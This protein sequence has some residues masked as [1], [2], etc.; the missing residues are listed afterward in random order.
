[1]LA[2]TY[3]A[4]TLAGL[5]GLA[6]P[7]AAQP[8]ETQ[9]AFPSYLITR[10]P[11]PAVS[12]VTG[13]FNADGL[14][15]LVWISDPV[16]GGPSDFG[17]SITV[18]LSQGRGYFS[19]SAVIEHAASELAVADFDNDGDDDLISNSGGVT[20]FESLGDGSF[21]EYQWF[22]VPVPDSLNAADITGD[23][24]P[25]FFADTEI[26][27]FKGNGYTWNPFD[28]EPLR[29]ATP[30]FTSFLHDVNA[31]GVP[32]LVYDAGSTLGIQ[33]HQIDGSPGLRDNITIYSRPETSTAPFDRYIARPGMQPGEL[34]AIT[35]R[36]SLTPRAFVVTFDTS[37]VPFSVSSQESL[38]GPGTSS[39]FPF[40]ESQ[41][42]ITDFDADGFSDRINQFAGTVRH[43]FLANM[44]GVGQ[45][46][47]V[48]D[49]LAGGPADAELTNSLGARQLF[50]DVTGDGA[51]DIL[52][53]GRTVVSTRSATTPLPE[54]STPS[55]ATNIAEFIDPTT[56]RDLISGDFDAD[57]RP[58][59]AAINPDFIVAYA[60]DQT[61]GT[62][63]LRFT[64]R[65]AAQTTGR[66]VV[67]DLNGD[68]VSDLLTVAT[69]SSRLYALTSTAPR[70][71]ESTPID[72]DRPE[73]ASVTTP[74]VADLDNDGDLDIILLDTVSFSFEESY[75]IDRVIVLENDGGVYT[76][77][78]RVTLDS[79]TTRPDIVTIDVDADGFL[80]VVVP[81]PDN[82][83]LRVLPGL[84]DLTFA[85]QTAIPLGFAVRN[86]DTVDL[87]NDG[88]QELVWTRDAIIDDNQYPLVV[89]AVARELSGA[90]DLLNPQTL[91]ISRT[92]ILDAPLVTR[93]NNDNLDDIT[94]GRFTLLQRASGGFEA[95]ER[96]GTYTPFDIDADGDQDLVDLRSDPVSAEVVL[97][98][99][100]TYSNCRAD[101]DAD[102]SLTNNDL[103][104]FV[105]QFLDADPRTDMNRDTVL[106]ITDILELVDRFLGGC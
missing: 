72:F 57:G 65:L 47:E 69:G 52:T 93:I 17:L 63:T 87:G 101:V 3:H 62:P 49:G 46:I 12:M 43:R 5:A 51:P 73:G 75:P 35:S 92:T 91:A 77:A 11:T 48:P 59:L 98:F 56:R 38:P 100:S 54:V 14:P 15:D 37:E 106:D 30:R 99:P 55:V 90:L 70:T 102:G 60:A 41:H 61:P 83:A 76:E 64:E 71:F 16:E 4:A 86:L 74:T 6:A 96:T 10:Q 94:V 82:N 67:A 26:I 24:I 68:G 33:L 13:D 95:F 40:N 9:F 44:S 32:D 23:G 81:E 88:T 22:S 85:E 28:D 53:P 105:T 27:A 25:E 50:I 66:R 7:L 18:A 31:D 97:A 34:I 39:F 29:S 20:L 58:D 79:N 21:E 8:I 89:Q 104:T 78:H 103:S 42:T 19:E 36:S 45:A 1:M 84:G 80:D 2:R